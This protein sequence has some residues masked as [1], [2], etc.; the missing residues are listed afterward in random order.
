MSQSRT[1][2]GRLAALSAT[3][4]TVATCGLSAQA[5]ASTS[6]GGAPVGGLA[7][8]SQR[9]SNNV[10]APPS[11]HSHGH[12][13]HGVSITEYWPAP[14]WWFVGRKVKVPG[15]RGRHRID[16]LYSAMGVSMEGDGIGL[17]GHRYHLENPGRGGWVTR[18]GRSTSASDGFASG[19]PYW[20]AG[21]YWRNRHGGV[22]FPL[23]R[24]GWSNGVGGKYIPLRGVTF[25]SGPSLP[26]RFYQSLAVD[27]HL[28]PL[29]SRIYIPAY[30]HDG[31]GGWFIAQDTG[32]AINGLH[33]DV[34]RNPPASKNDSG[35][36]LVNRRIYVIKPPKRH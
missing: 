34:Y 26:L 10:P 8:T 28:I 36:Y 15:L 1:R 7:P 6:S 11:K 23:A 32:G 21:G 31:H 18:S 4:I 16:W 24:G 30:R 14:E 17:D 25:A 9:K 35:Q 5:S 33:V 29:G 2:L 27:P 22:T 20:R 13:L 3:L 19:P 12:W